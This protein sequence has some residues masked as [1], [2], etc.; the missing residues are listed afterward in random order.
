MLE[1]THEVTEGHA[2]LLWG[3]QHALK[4]EL[5]FTFR[6]QRRFFFHRLERHF[7]HVEFPRGI[8]Y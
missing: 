7:W 3:N 8:E 6:I 2:S 5:V 4:D 1:M